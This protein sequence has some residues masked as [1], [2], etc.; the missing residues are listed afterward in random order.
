MPRKK[1]TDYPMAKQHVFVRG[2][3]RMTIARDE[4]DYEHSLL[5]LARTV[6][7]FDIRC[8][9][10]CFLPNHSHLLITS[11]LG[12]LSKAMHWF[13][14]CSAQAFNRRYERPGHVYQGRFGS[15]VVTD[16]DYLLE[17]G[18][19]VPLNPVRAGLCDEAAD[20]PWSSY[21]ATAGLRT[22]PW[23]LDASTLVETL[24]STAGYAQWVAAG[25]HGSP[26]DGD[27]VPLKPSRPSL[28][29]LLPE[30]SVSGIAVAHFEHGYT[31]R[32]IAR[33]LGVSDSQI[34]RRLR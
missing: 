23:F 24:G 5:L 19:Y 16:D 9:A 33:H 11:Q 31:K 25:V 7:R 28:E 1:R 32:A 8:H 4:T 17:L 34:G 26:L 14:T 15:R 18:R 6:A 30:G 10:W 29:I 20:W 27:G 3:G 21:A 12:N 22:P 2:V 13:G